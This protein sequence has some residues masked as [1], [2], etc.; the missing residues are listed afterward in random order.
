[1][2]SASVLDEKKDKVIDFY[3]LVNVKVIPESDFS[4]LAGWKES[5]LNI[6]T[7]EDLNEA[8]TKDR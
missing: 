4:F 1:V 7:P 8:R 6:N 5:F 2:P 3:P